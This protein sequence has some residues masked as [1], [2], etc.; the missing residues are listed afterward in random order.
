MQGFNP[1]LNFRYSCICIDC[2]CPCARNQM[3]GEL[4]TEKPLKEPVC[5]YCNHPIVLTHIALEHIQTFIEPVLYAWA[6]EKHIEVSLVGFIPFDIPTAIKLQSVIVGIDK[7]KANGNRAGSF[8]ILL[9]IL[10]QGEFAISELPDV[11]LL[12]AP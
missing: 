7:K 8:H 9:F 1:E 12:Q 2:S 4:I 10:D 6:R 5:P 11:F 3:H